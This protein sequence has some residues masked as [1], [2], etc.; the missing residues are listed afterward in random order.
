M[1]PISRKLS[2]LSLLNQRSIGGNNRT[3]RSYR[4]IFNEVIEE[5]VIKNNYSHENNENKMDKSNTRNWF[6]PID[7]IEKEQSADARSTIAIAFS[8]D[9]TTF[10]TTH[11]DHAV[12]IFYFDSCK[13]YRAFNGHPRTPWTVKYHPI[14][15]NIVASGCLGYEVRIWNISK[16]MCLNTIIYDSSIISLAFHPLG[17]FIAVSSGPHLYTWDWKE[18]MAFANGG[19]PIGKGPNPKRRLVVHS[20]NIRAVMFH[21]NGNF[22]IYLI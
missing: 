17:E 15:S 1:K 4:I 5:S 14:D 8:P 13:M 11:G 6:G 20:R 3:S 12:K 10:A 16:G 22:Y 18:G 19:Y 21:P 9:G 7:C 2:L